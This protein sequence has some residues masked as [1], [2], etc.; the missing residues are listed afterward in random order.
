MD[1]NLLTFPDK[2]TLSKAL[3]MAVQSQLQDALSQTGRASILLSGGSTPKDAYKTLSQATLD[4]KNVEIGL[5]DDRWV[6]EDNAG[7]N[8]GMI[9]RTLL[10]HKAQD[11]KFYPLKSKTG[12]L[13]S[14]CEA[15]NIVYKKM[16]QP[17][18]A[19][20]LGMGTDGHTASWFPDAQ[21]LAAALDPTSERYITDIIAKPTDVTGPYLERATLT[22]AGLKHAANLHLLIT[23]AEK[24]R[25]FETAFNDPVST[26]PIAHAIRAYGSKMTVYWT[27]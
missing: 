14:G 3:T 1:L 4:W 21:G 24:R 19:A 25:V 6:D 20:V 12:S 8:A 5:V 15:A 26:A 27:T 18:C 22:L 9:R 16:T 13:Q 10:T 17:F 2:S 7:S 11:A 23:G